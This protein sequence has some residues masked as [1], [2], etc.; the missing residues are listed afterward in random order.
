[1]DIVGKSYDKPL[2]IGS[3]AANMKLNPAYLGQL[4]LHCTGQTFHTLLLDARISQACRLLKQTSHTIGE[5]AYMVGFRD[6]DYFSLKF[7][8]RMT[9]NPNAYRGTAGEKE[10]AGNETPHQ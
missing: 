2:S 3:I 10:D 7:R 9:M 6:V 8:S 1:L 4:I 5:I